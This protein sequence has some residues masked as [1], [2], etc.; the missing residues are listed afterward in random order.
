MMV[1]FVEYFA[2]PYVVGATKADKIAKPSGLTSAPAA[3][4]DSLIFAYEIVPL[5]SEDGYGKEK[6]LGILEPYLQSEEE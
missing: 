1:Q 2:I 3:P 4:A 6:L 5:S